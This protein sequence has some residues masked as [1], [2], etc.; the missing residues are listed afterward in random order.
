MDSGRVYVIGASQPGRETRVETGV[1]FLTDLQVYRY[2]SP[3]ML[4]PLPDVL[5]PF[6]YAEKH[7]HLHG[8]LDLARL[9]RLAGSLLE[10]SGNVSIDLHFARDGRVPC[11]TGRVAASLVLECQCCLES[12][13]WPVNVEVSLGVVRTVDES[14]RLP[15][16]VEALIVGAEGEVS[17]ADIVQD[18]LL[19][20]IP[21][22]P[23]HPDCKLAA[24]SEPV[25][26][27]RPHPFAALA[28][29]KN[30]LPS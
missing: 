22:I 7:R 9:D 20:A 28:Q 4:D 23:R 16:S 19:L 30:K 18:E 12:M 2:Y 25:A 8:E 26:A 11:I 27:E 3:I 15:D 21:A 6:V 17:L 24:A 14:L 10:R 29:L 5:D 1:W 13:A